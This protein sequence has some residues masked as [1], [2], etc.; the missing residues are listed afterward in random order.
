MFEHKIDVLSVGD[1]V[2]DAFIRLLPHEAEVTTNP[3]NHHPLLCMT[4]GT[5]VPFE[6]ATIIK[7]VG[8][9]PNAAV[10]FSR[11]GLNSSLYANVGDDRVGEDILIALRANEVSTEFVRVNKGMA[12]NYHY[13]L[14]YDHERTI[15]INHEKYNYVLPDIKPKYIY[16]SSLGE[17]I[18]ECVFYGRDRGEVN[19]SSSIGTEK[20]FIKQEYNY[21][22]VDGKWEIY[23]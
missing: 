17:N 5:K 19:V 14:W 6:K 20:Q 8:N 23:Y 2:T 13:V 22:F 7:G 11:L 21:L 3:K 9:S 15:L 4:F 1:V 16:L 12:S 18:K 10:C